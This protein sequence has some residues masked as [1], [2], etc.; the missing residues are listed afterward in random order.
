M[1]KAGVLKDLDVFRAFSDVQLEGL[2]KII[3]KRTF[4]KGALVYKRSYRADRIYLVTKGLV[5]LDKLEPGEKIGISVEHR[6]KG[7]L[8]GTACFMKPQE[9]TLTAVCQKDTEVVAID[10]DKLG[11]LCKDDPDLGYKFMKEVAQIYFERYKAAKRQI[12]EMVRTPTVITA[13]SG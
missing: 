6:E 5:G 4:E 2:S 12:H 3:K 11:E 9:Y 13:L 10:A 7:E 8:F 1:I